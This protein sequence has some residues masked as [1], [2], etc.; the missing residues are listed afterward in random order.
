[1]V[2]D[3]WE[4]QRRARSRTGLYVTLFVLLTLIVA[5]IAE[6][7]LRYF[8]QEDYNPPVPYLGLLFLAITFI[9]A[10]FQYGM[11]RSYGGKYVAESVGGRLVS[12]KTT[13][14]KEKQLLN[15]VEETALAAS[16][17][18]PDVYILDAKEINAFAAGLSP[19]DAVIT[20]T[21]GSLNILNRDELQGVIAHEFG[22]IHNGDMV[23][24]MRLAAMVMGFFFVLYFGIR[25]LQFSGL[26]GR[27][28]G[29]RRGVNPV[30]IA[31][32]ILLVAGVLTWFAGSLLKCAVSREREYLADASSVQFTRNPNG[33]A[34]ALRKI[35][36]E[37]VHDMPKEGI[38]FSHMYLED[39][40]AWSRLF[41]THPPL[42]KRIAAIE[43]RT[44]IPEEWKIPPKS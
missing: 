20:V 4:A 16:V 1:M 27:N 34:G 33:I 23:I 24:S 36:N 21:W 14:Y 32:L 17:P 6:L 43:G 28:N 10:L 40:S 7:A 37:Q 15:I 29:E 3:F 18:V 26:R 42:D 25:L 39:T 38:T 35:A 30:L 11:F 22:H 13:S 44:Y 31:A 12:P 5:T 8:A 19:S 9:V 2:M 41:A